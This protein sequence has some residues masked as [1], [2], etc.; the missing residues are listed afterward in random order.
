MG[1]EKVYERI[2]SLGIERIR[3]NV[4]ERSIK[5]DRDREKY[6]LVSEFGGREIGF[7]L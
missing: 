1:R 4:R 2:V 6:I 3:D 7:S 5:R